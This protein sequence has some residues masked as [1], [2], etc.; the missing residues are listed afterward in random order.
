M[1]SPFQSKEFF[2]TEEPDVMNVQLATETTIN[3]SGRD[4]KLFKPILMDF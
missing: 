2:H 4:A 1:I 3:L